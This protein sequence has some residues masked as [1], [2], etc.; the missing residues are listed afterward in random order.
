M[1]TAVTAGG[2]SNSFTPDF[3]ITQHI[4]PSQIFQS[5]H[6]AQPPGVHM[7]NKNMFSFGADS[8]G[9][10]EDRGTFADW[11]IKHKSALLPMEDPSME[12]EPCS[13]KWDV[14]LTG[15][16]NMQAARYPIGSHKKQ[17]T[18]RGT[19]D[20]GSVEGDGLGGSLGRTHAST[21]SVSN[22]CSRNRNDRRQN[23][24]QT[25]S[26]PNKALMGQPASMLEQMSNPN[27]P[28]D[29]SNVSEFES[30][31]LSLLSPRG[32]KH[33]SSTNLAGAAA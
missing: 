33:G 23:I 16:F 20:M 30:A 9:D 10:K 2:Q 5:D 15:Q 14:G 24:P 18:I 27:S 1:F 8:D 17:V 31:V 25:A 28:S 22:N 26:T 13:F 29:L 11:I 32:S 7:G 6:P 4:D 21:Q 19:A 12:M 3:G